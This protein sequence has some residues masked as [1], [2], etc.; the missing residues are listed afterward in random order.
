MQPTGHDQVIDQA[1]TQQANAFNESAVANSATLLDAILDGAAPRPSERWLEA[2]C[3]PGVIS[4]ALAPRV[5]AVHGVDITAAM[6]E[7]ARAQASAA[8]LENLTF[9]A[10]DATA[11]GLESA[12]FDGAVTRFSVHHLPVPARLFDELARLIRPGGTL[13]V[14]DHLAEGGLEPYA[15]SQELERLRDPSHWASVSAARLRALGDQAGFALERERRFPFELDFDDWLHRGTADP[16]AWELVEQALAER[17]DGAECFTVTERG[18]AR[19]LTLQM[20]L[21]R[22]RRR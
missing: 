9:E 1:F 14:V 16:R 5:A 11:T 8:G 12:S 10:G 21:G 4:R 19:I 6:V 15:W 18:G 13:V 2:A 3:G 20:W 7:L 22:W 17:P